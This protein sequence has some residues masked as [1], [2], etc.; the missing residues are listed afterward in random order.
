MRFAGYLPLPTY[1][2]IP[3]ILDQKC[4][5]FSD[6]TQTIQIRNRIHFN[7]E[8]EMRCFFFSILVLFIHLFRCDFI[9]IVCALAE[10]NL[11]IWHR[12]ERIRSNQQDSQTVFDQWHERIYTLFSAAASSSSSSIFWKHFVRVGVFNCFVSYMCNV[13][14]MSFNLTSR[15][16]YAL[17]RAYKLTL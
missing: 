6:T 9:Y 3:Y 12:W 11:V 2:Y 16:V 4:D 1:S 5:M 15:L 13:R 8:G 7:G 14:M 10:T 17:C